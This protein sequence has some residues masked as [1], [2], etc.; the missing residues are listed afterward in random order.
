MTAK[1]DEVDVTS[2]L[3]HISYD[4]EW[5]LPANSSMTAGSSK[6]LQPHHN[7]PRDFVHRTRDAGVHTTLFR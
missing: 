6:T 5:S 1:K 2:Q 4:S 7:R 3:G